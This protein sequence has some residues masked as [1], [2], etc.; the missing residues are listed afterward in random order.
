MGN[1]ARVARKL[2]PE[3]IGSLAKL[4][5]KYVS[6]KDAYLGRAAWPA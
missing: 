1:P 6:V 2:T 5:D 3:E 4:A